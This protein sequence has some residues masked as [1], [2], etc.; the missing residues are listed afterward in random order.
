MKLLLAEVRVQS[1]RQIKTNECI[2]NSIS[3]QGAKENE[4]GMEQQLGEAHQMVPRRTSKEGA[5]ELVCELKGCQLC[6]GLGKDH[7][8]ASRQRRP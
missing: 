7:S 2:K 5:F 3:D 6:H 1:R 4:L 8:R